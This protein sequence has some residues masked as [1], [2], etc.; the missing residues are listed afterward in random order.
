MAVLFVLPD[1]ASLEREIPLEIRI[2]LDRLS[3]LP[4]KPEVD[5]LELVVKADLTRVFK[6]RAEIHLVDTRPINGAHAH[7][8]GGAARIDFAALQHLRPLGHRVGRAFGPRNQLEIPLVAI[9]AQQR[10]GV[11]AAARVNDGGHF[12]VIDRYA[13]Q[14]NA[15]LAAANDLAI[16]DDDGSERPAPSLFDGFDAETGRLVQELLFIFVTLDV[17]GAHVWY[18]RWLIVGGGQRL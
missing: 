9:R 12:G 11:D 6:A 2:A 15:V 14:Q 5:V 18:C 8:A 10:L 3:L 1:F 13:R 17:R 7:R 4:R 16:L